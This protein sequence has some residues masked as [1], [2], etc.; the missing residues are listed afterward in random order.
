MSAAEFAE[1]LKR[2]RQVR[3]ARDHDFDCPT[4]SAP[5]FNVFGT[6]KGHERPIAELHYQNGSEQPSDILV[7]T[8]LLRATQGL[9]ALEDL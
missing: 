1:Y 6:Y 4:V 5:L 8:H 3:Y 9:M 7:H 2:F